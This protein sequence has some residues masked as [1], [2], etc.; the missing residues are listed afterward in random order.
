MKKLGFQIRNLRENKG[1]SQSELARNAGISNDYM[2]KIELSKVSNVGIEILE[3]IAQALGTSAAELIYEAELNKRPPNAY[4]APSYTP[5]DVPVVGLAKAGRG[6][7]FDNLGHPPGDWPH[8]IHRPEDVTDPLAY[9]V[10]VDG[11]SME[12]VLKKG[13]KVMV[14][15]DKEAQNGDWVVVQLKSGEIMVKELTMKDGFVLLK[16]LNPLHEPVMVK[17]SEVRAIHPVVWIKRK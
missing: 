1:L 15:T 12:P 8:K 3:A 10:T 4:D 16:S 7:F 6:G 9:A 5:H 11:D 13:H 2:N 14:V 17:K